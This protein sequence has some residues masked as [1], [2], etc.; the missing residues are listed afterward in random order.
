M[1]SGG[2]LVAVSGREGLSTT[3]G[4]RRIWIANDK[5]RALQVFLVV[6]FR[7]H[8][9]LDAHGVD[10]EGYTHVN[11]LAV[12]LFDVL[13]EGEAILKAGATT[14]RNEHSELKLIIL[15]FFN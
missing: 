10:N 13:I 9:V 5:L 4:C 14:A 15:L 2:E 7:A 12:T 1:T 11:D 3:A 6:N 8:Q